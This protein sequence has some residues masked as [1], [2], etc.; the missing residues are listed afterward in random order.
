M[1]K[2]SAEQRLRTL[3]EGRLREARRIQPGWDP[4]TADAWHP[5][6]YKPSAVILREVV[7]ERSADWEVLKRPRPGQW[8]WERCVTWLSANGPRQQPD[9]VEVSQADVDVFESTDVPDDGVAGA[10]RV[11]GPPSPRPT[12]PRPTRSNS[13]LPPGPSP[14]PPAKKNWA[15][16]RMGPRLA[17]VCVE[18]REH[19][20]DK[21]R[22]LTRQELDGKQQNRFWAM[23]ATAFNNTANDDVDTNMFA[24][25]EGYSEAVRDVDPSPVPG[26][27]A[28]AS[29]LKE[30]FTTI[31]SLLMKCLN[32]FR[33][34]GQ[35]DGGSDLSEREKNGEVFSATFE[36]FVPDPWLFYV[37]AALAKHD[38]LTTTLVLMDKDA[39]HDGTT[40][41]S[42]AITRSR[43]RDISG[44]LNSM[45]VDM[46]APIQIAMSE[47]QRLEQVAKR[48]R[49]QQLATIGEA[50]MEEKL[51]EKEM[52]LIAKYTELKNKLDNLDE[53]SFEHRHFTRIQALVVSKLES[54]ADAPDLPV[55]TASAPPRREEAPR[56][57]RRA[58][59]PVRRT[60]GRS[61]GEIMRE[62]PTAGAREQVAGEE[63]KGEELENL[64]IWMHGKF[65][66]ESFRK[67]LGLDS[68]HEGHA[69]AMKWLENLNTWYPGYLSGFGRGNITWEGAADILEREGLLE[70]EDSEPSSIEDLTRT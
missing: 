31:R 65:G 16:H 53:S 32:D 46:A 44:S 61:F 63:E 9:L 4:M 67:D 17:N 22:T 14:A 12:S 29:K 15:K 24:A 35:G 45:A 60:T 47:D 39:R 55:L 40:P 58:A 54:K 11:L 21:D 6:K 37:Y 50:E 20:L 68:S 69:M 19:F 25:D 41:S 59:P 26:F 3:R 43:K 64:N 62:E 36:K 70:R 57:V 34:S 18:L 8:T 52:A 30:E 27:L 33:I 1:A 38:L 28:K 42:T 51:I 5:R 10:L 2:P 49:A 13:R 23:A 48:A 7:L 56:P 66:S